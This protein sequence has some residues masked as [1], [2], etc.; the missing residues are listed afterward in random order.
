MKK[1]YKKSMDQKARAKRR[2]KKYL[3]VGT[4]I[5][6]GLMLGTAPI[7]I[8]TPLFTI[9]SQQVRNRYMLIWLA[10]SF[11]IILVRRIQAERALGHLT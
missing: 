11:L 5:A 7:T 4:S 9:G 1:D 6:A 8:A 3:L 10:D 2:S